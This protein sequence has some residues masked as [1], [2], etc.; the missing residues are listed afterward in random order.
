[1]VHRDRRRQNRQDYDQR[2]DRRVLESGRSDAGHGHHRGPGWSRL[3][4]GRSQ[5]DRQDHDERER[6]RRADGLAFGTLLL[7][8]RV[9]HRRVCVIGAEV[10]PTI[11]DGTGD[12]R[13]SPRR[14]R[15]PLTAT[16]DCRLPLRWCRR[17]SACPLAPAP[18]SRS[19]RSSRGG[20]SRYARREAPAAGSRAAASSTRDP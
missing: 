11:P 20:E 4:R 6:L 5:Q 10:T 13:A 19:G 1:M 18:R 17:V 8:G 12:L 14:P 16:I 3:V 2:R 7:R 9:G 15:R